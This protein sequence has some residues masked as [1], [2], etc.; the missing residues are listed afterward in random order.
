[1]EKRTVR[2]HNDKYVVFYEFEDGAFA[3]LEEPDSEPGDGRTGDQPQE[4]EDD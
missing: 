3:D 2:N 1:M 4:G